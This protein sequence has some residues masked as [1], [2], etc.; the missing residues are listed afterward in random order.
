MLIRIDQILIKTNKILAFTVR[1]HR[2][3]IITQSNFEKN[4]SSK[5]KDKKFLGKLHFFLISIFRNPYEN[6]SLIR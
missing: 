4:T 1:L 2:V 5:I 3:Y 6:I